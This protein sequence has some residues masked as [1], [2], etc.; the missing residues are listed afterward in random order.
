MVG[1]AKL[2]TARI[3][4]LLEGQVRVLAARVHTGATRAAVGELPTSLP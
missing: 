3:E 4:D 2:K 1:T